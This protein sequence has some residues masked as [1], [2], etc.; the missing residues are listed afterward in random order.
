MLDANFELKPE[1]VGLVSASTKPAILAALAEKFSAIYGVDQMIVEE[2]LAERE[3]LGSTGFGRG[4]AIPH[5]RVGGIQRPVSVVLRLKSPIDFS[6]ADGMPVDLVFGLLSP[7][8]SGAAHLHALAAISRL[9]RDDAMREALSEAVN[10]EALYSMI[11]N[12]T[13]RDVA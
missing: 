5:A 3:A 13:D 6:A 11:S 2:A 10:G 1:A 4:A 12:V 8:G 9:V 7:E